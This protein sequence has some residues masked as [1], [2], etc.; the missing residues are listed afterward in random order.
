L[1]CCLKLAEASNA[2][3][4]ETIGLLG[5][6]P[7]TQTSDSKAAVD[8]CITIAEAV[9]EYRDK[10]ASLSDIF[11]VTNSAARMLRVEDRDQVA[12]AAALQLAR[13]QNLLGHAG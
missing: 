10:K 9:I 11:R 8:T 1:R 6:S 3:D 7:P 4:P 5:V 12:N 2:V 13:K